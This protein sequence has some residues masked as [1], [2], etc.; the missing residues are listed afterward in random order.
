MLGDTTV[1][2]CE[3]EGA[4]DMKA[5]GLN[6]DGLVWLRAKSFHLWG[7]KHIEHVLIAKGTLNEER[8]GQ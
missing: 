8:K 1:N 6:L 5:H 7:Q 4:S 3:Q 2:W